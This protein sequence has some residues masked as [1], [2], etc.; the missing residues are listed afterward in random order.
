[1]EEKVVKNVR[2]GLRGDFKNK[3][4]FHKTVR[5]LKFLF[6]NLTRC[7]T[8]VQ[9]FDFLKKFLRQNRDF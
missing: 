2:D 6:Q 7:K 8:F 4:I 3:L 5:F 1:M 9:K